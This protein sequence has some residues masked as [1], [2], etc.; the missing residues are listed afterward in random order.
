MRTRG[1]LQPSRTFG[2]ISRMRA[3][4]S[5]YIVEISARW[6]RSWWR[7]ASTHPVLVAGELEVDV[8]L[9]VGEGVGGE[10]GEAL[11]RGSAGPTARG[12][13]VVG[14]DQRH[15]GAV[16]VMVGREDVE[17]DHVDAVRQR[18]VEAREGVPGRDVVGAL[19]ADA[20]QLRMG[21][22]ALYR[23]HPGHQ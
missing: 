6:T 8:E 4:L 13:V 20:A 10:V 15:A 11:G 19:V 22:R 1:T 21:G 17:L 9:D 2:S 7:S 3:R 16:G 12:P 14:E 5:G 18:R 23:W